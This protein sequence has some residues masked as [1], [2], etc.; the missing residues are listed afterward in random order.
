[1]FLIFEFHTPIFAVGMYFL[2]VN[3][4]RDV[5]KESVITSSIALKKEFKSILGIGKENLF[6]LIPT[7]LLY[8]L[9]IIVLGI[10]ISFEN[11]LALQIIFYAVLTPAHQ[12]YRTITSGPVSLPH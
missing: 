9:V 2:F 5:L 1:M 11:L 6:I 4:L 12:F 7:W 3:S 8:T 10:P